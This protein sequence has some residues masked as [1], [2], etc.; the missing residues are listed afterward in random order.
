MGGSLDSIIPCTYWEF[1]HLAD[2]V[3]QAEIGASCRCHPQNGSAGCHLPADVDI[4]VGSGPCQPYSA[5]RQGVNAN[6]KPIMEH[7]GYDTTF[8]KQGSLVSIVRRVLPKVYISEQVMGFGNPYDKKF[9]EVCPKHDFVDTIMQITG[10]DG[11]EH[12]KKCIVLKLDSKLMLEAG[13]PRHSGATW[14]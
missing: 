6:T 11:E 3:L 7:H 10:R 9:P 4:L 14:T 5:L 1:G 2:H 12:F 8:G 13:R